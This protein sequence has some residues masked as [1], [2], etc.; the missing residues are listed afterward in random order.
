MVY[1]A[2]IKLNNNI[3]RFNQKALNLDLNKEENNRLKKGY[4][5][6]LHRYAHRRT[7][8]STY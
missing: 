1:Y 7:G 6:F 4:Y 8:P 2:L 3:D 5:Y